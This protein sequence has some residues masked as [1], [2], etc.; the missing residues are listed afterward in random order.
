M[1]SQVIAREMQSLGYRAELNFHARD[2]HPFIASATQGKPFTVTAYKSVYP[3]F[4]SIF[5]EIEFP[6]DLTGLDCSIYNRTPAA[7]ASRLFVRDFSKL[8]L[9]AD[10]RVTPRGL[11]ADVPMVMHYWEM[12]ITELTRFITTHAT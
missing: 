11:A 3:L 10:H 6:H 5:A 1:P 2:D 7:F 4:L 9:Y 8:N 12:N